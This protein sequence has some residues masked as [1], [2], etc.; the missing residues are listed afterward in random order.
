ME[1]KK[2]NIVGI[3]NKY[4]IKKLLQKNKVEK[5]RVISKTWNIQEEY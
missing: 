4:Q 2:I 5:K 3:N 1:N